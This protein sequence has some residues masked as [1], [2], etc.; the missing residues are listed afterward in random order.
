VAHSWQVLNG[1]A[2]D[3]TTK[4]L[5]VQVSRKLIYFYVINILILTACKENLQKIMIL[6]E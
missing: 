4:I 1:V 2:I 3:F 5:I 6:K